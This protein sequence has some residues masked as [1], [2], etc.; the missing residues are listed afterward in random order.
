MISSRWAH[1]GPSQVDIQAGVDLAQRVD[2]KYAPVWINRTEHEQA[3]LAWYFLPH[4]SSKTTL[5]VT[6]PR[7]IKW[8]CPFADQRQFPSGHR[9]CINIYTGC[10]HRCA[11]CYA[12]GYEPEHVSVKKDFERLIKKDLE[13]LDRFDV[14]PA[15]VHLS[16]S[17]DPFQPLELKTGHTKFALEQILIHRHRFTTVTILT[18]NPLLLTKQKYLD[19]LKDL[20]EPA[21][22]R[23]EVSMAFWQ[24]KTRQAFEPSAPPIQA[25]IEGIQALRESGIPI[26]LRIDPLFPRPVQKHG[27]DTLPQTIDDLCALVEF[28]KRNGTMHVVYSAVKITQPRGRAISHIME[29]IRAIYADLAGPSGLVF[30]GGSWRLPENITNNSVIQ[31]FLDICRNYAMPAK[32]CM[33]NL[34]ETH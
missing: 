25:R 8:Y 23:A 20:A 32:H 4:R 34:I 21:A 26:V 29:S 2:R 28:A 15:P 10:E 12:A 18:K 13:D 24:D 17:T 33:Q 27:L 14:P 16:N 9:Y 19:L 11:Y 3:A 31:P 6:R 1:M 7:V 22:L 5:G 30:H